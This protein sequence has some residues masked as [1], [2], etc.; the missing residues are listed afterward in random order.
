MKFRILWI[1]ILTSFF[2]SI[3]W[4]S[5][6]AASETLSDCSEEIMASGSGGF[7]ACRVQDLLR[8]EAIAE[9]KHKQKLKTLEEDHPELNK[10]KIKWLQKKA[11]EA[12]QYWKKYKS[13]YCSEFHYEIVSGTGRSLSAVLCA[14]LLTQHRI[15][16]LEYE[17]WVCPKDEVIFIKATYNLEIPLYIKCESL[18]FCFDWSIP[19]M[20]CPATSPTGPST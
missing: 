13:A 17:F 4:A 20:D 19:R 18:L 1:I 12:H 2:F 7:T 5:L 14:I 8:L 6:A 10:R 11:V 16:E 3:S 15:E 9:E